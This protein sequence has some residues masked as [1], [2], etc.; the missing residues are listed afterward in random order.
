MYSLQEV[1]PRLE[2]AL[3][4]K[5]GRAEVADLARLTG[6]ATKLTYSFTAAFDG[7]RRKFIL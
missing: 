3:A 5:F 1:G 2:A 7:A 6:G 4:R